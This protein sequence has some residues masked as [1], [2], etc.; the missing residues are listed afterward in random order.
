MW[1]HEFFFKLFNFKLNQLFFENPLFTKCPLEIATKRNFC[2]WKSLNLDPHSNAHWAFKC[3]YALSKVTSRARAVGLNLQSE[4]LPG[5]FFDEE[6]TSLSYAVHTYFVGNYQLSVASSFRLSQTQHKYV[7]V[8][9]I[10]CNLILRTG[11]T[12]WKIC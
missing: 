10:L 7:I 2:P 5:F 12:Y 9:I 3:E 6:G 1:F 4:L 8:W 11:S